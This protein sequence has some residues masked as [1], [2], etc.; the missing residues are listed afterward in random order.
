MSRPYVAQQD[1]YEPPMPSVEV[2]DIRGHLARVRQRVCVADG[3]PVARSSALRSLDEADRALTHLGTGMPRTRVE[4]IN[5]RGG[6]FG[7]GGRLDA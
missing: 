3:D 2:Q 1:R 4:Q 6:T 5:A 7:V